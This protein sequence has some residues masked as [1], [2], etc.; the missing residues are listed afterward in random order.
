[1][2][3]LADYYVCCSIAHAFFAID[4][5]RAMFDPDVIEDSVA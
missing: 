2:T 3:V 4:D 5:F 1:M